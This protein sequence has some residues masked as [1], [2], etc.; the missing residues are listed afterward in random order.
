MSKGASS[1]SGAGGCTVFLRRAGG[2]LAAVVPPVAAVRAGRV[3][4]A[5]DRRSVLASA[6]GGGGGY[7]LSCATGSGSDASTGSGVG[8]TAGIGIVDSGSALRATA[9]RTGAE[10]AAGAAGVASV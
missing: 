6:D 9:A 7:A 3:V 8:T 4:C 1:R 2:E 10:A 5:L